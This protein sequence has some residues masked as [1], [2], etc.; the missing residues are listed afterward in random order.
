MKFWDTFNYCILKKLHPLLTF[1]LG[2]LNPFTFFQITN[3]LNERGFSDG[4]ETW[5]FITDSGTS[6]D[7]TCRSVI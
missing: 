1:A 5:H 3:A 2:A 6:Y 7:I 4:L